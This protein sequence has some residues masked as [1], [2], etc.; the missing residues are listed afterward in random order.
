MNLVHGQGGILRRLL[1]KGE[2]S[3]LLGLSKSQIRFYEKKELLTPRIDENGY[4]MY[5]FSEIDTL[6]IILVLKDLNMSIKEI[7]AVLDESEDYDYERFIKRSYDQVD[8]EI[9]ALEIKKHK[10]KQKLQVYQHQNTEAF[11]IEPYP[12][13]QLLLVGLE[14]INTAK[15]VYDLINKSDMKFTNYDHELYILTQDGVDTAGFYSIS[16]KTYNY[17]FEKHTLDAGDYFSYTKRFDVDEAYDSFEA[18]FLKEAENRNLELEGPIIYIDHFGRRFYSR[19]HGVY[20][21]Q[22]KIKSL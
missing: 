1:T 15:Q 13:R 8:Q 5:G 19:H 14:E 2:V 9:K 16:G 6:E 10:L 11:I 22:S 7:K 4:A 18:Q 20:T 21:L 3:S 12:V 17:D